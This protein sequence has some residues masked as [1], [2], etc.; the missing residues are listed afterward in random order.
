M[1][2]LFQKGNSHQGLTDI[3]P[4]PPRGLQGHKGSWIQQCSCDPGPEPIQCPTSWETGSSA[5]QGGCPQDRGSQWA[6][7]PEPESQLPWGPPLPAAPDPAA[8]P[9][10][11]EPPQTCTSFPGIWPTWGLQMP[12]SATS[13]TSVAEPLC[14]RRHSPGAQEL[15]CPVFLSLS[16]PCHSLYKQL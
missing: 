9:P 6:H 5:Q 12:W 13:T 10:A 16:K 3:P 14:T 11:V 8:P 4:H 7:S 2:A 1:T 15:G